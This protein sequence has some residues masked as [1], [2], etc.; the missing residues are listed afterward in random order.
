MHVAKTCQAAPFVCS[1]PRH[2]RH[3]T[4]THKTHTAHT[5]SGLTQG[6]CDRR[7]AKASD[8]L[9]PSP[10]CTAGPPGHDAMGHGPGHAPGAAA[11]NTTSDCFT[12]CAYEAML[13]RGPSFPNATHT[14]MSA[15]ELV[16]PWLLSFQTEDTAAGGCPQV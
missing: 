5:H 13:G 2:S 7:R 12:I 15:A 4:H 14:G 10:A 6:R 11:A 3:T 8:C 1:E 9:A 16:D